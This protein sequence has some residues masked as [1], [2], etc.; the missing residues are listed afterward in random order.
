MSKKKKSFSELKNEALLKK[1]DKEVETLCKKCGLCCHVKVGL[2]DG[3]YIVHPTMP[4]KYLNNDNTCAVYDK[5]FK[6]DVKCFTREEMIN[7]DYLLPEGCP[8]TELRKGYK[9]AK[10]VTQ[11]EFDDIILKEIE[12]GNYNVLLVNR[13]S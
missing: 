7:K 3:N 1:K 12:S 6:C 4:C 2:L 10:V 9:P 13:I 8:Y 5:R 11:A